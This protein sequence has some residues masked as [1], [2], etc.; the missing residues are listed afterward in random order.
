MYRTALVTL[1]LVLATASLLHADPTP[2]ALAPRT[3]PA[4]A[5]RLASGVAWVTLVAGHGPHPRAT[6]WVLTYGGTSHSEREFYYSP[7]PRDAARFATFIAFTDMAIGEKRRY[8]L[9]DGS[10]EDI[11]IV[12]VVPR[13]RVNSHP[14]FPAPSDALVGT[15]GERYVVIEAAKPGTRIAPADRVMMR[16]V[17]LGDD[18]YVKLAIPE[19]RVTVDDITVPAV[20]AA[21]GSM[22][23]GERRM[24]WTTYL[25][26]PLWLYIEVFSVEHRPQITPPA[27]FAQIPRDARVASGA[28]YVVL[29]QG[30]GEPPDR[31]DGVTLD[32]AMWT[33][34]GR[35]I[36]STATNLAQAAG[37]FSFG[38]QLVD[39]RVGEHRRIWLQPELTTKYPEAGAGAVVDVRL[40]AIHR[41]LALLPHG[42]RVNTDGNGAV[43]LS[44]GATR[45]ALRLAI[46]RL[47]TMALSGDTVTF[48]GETDCDMPA[49][50]THSVAELDAIIDATEALQLAAAGKN[51]E[52]IHGLVSAIAHTHE[53]GELQF[54]LAAV[55]VAAGNPHDAAVTLAAVAARD[56]VTVFMRLAEDHTLAPLAGD[57]A[58]AR[59]RARKRGKVDLTKMP[60]MVD[61]S[62]RFAAVPIDEGSW[63]SGDSETRVEIIDLDTRAI[64]ATIPRAMWALMSQPITPAIEA[65]L[66]ARK[67]QVEAVLE[68]LGFASAAVEIATIGDDR[69]AH[70]ARAGITI[71][72]DLNVTR[73]GRRI[74]QAAG[75]GHPIAAYWLPA[76]RTLVVAAGRAGHEGCEGTDPRSVSVMKLP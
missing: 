14:V 76:R 34:S 44:R 51:V 1:L 69:V 74:A 35:T 22:G 23:S 49:A 29:E 13:D 65:E 21:V 63:G 12:A 9:P 38:S 56:P 32:Y 41:Q 62:G 73:A 68:T 39:M 66:A 50:E 27:G 43:A 52:A 45:V 48:S 8:W 17:A 71:D 31:V 54:R 42:L 28:H 26:K 37:E 19:D 70:F 4:N 5:T 59:F 36:E 18:D 20:A 2:A 61:P 60:V 57:A 75:V 33:L 55:Q 24:I 53:P 30:T 11:E 7:S 3:P 46:R 64:V 6:D 25:G 40:V 16:V 72:A 15:H 10:V 67:R 58:L 47:E